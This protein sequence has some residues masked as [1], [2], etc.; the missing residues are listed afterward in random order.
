M[1]QKFLNIKNVNITNIKN[2][3]IFCFVVSLV[4]S[5]L[6]VDLFVVFGAIFF[7]LIKIRKNIKID[8]NIFFFFLTFYTYLVIDSFFSAVPLQSLRSTLPYIRFI[9]FI[10]FIQYYFSD[11]SSLKTL[12]FSFFFVYFILLI[13]G[14]LQLQSGF[15]LFGYEIDQS[16]RVSSFFGRKLILGSFISKTFVIVI[17]LIFY[18]NIKHKYFLYLGTVIIST[19]LVYISRE[20]S[21]LFIFLLC[22]FFSFFL[23][24]KKSFI[25]IVLLVI[26]QIVVLLLLYKD[27]LQRHYYHTKSQLFDDNKKISS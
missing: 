26:F 1:L 11:R 8:S 17:F 24:N 9:L 6:I 16:G 20:R 23:V 21:A 22:L 7:I 15:N 27:P 5:R 10:F 14:I 25:K 13:D 4:F 12:L 2:I 3:F 18:L 19:L